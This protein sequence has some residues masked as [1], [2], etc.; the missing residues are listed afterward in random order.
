MKIIFKKQWGSLLPYNQTE[1]D[2][3]DKLKDDV[4]YEVD[5][6]TSSM[7]SIRQNS[8]IHLWCSQISNHL[9]NS[10][11]YV[12]DI[13]KTETKWSMEKVKENIFKA[14]VEQRYGK[15]STTKMLKNEFEDVID[16]IIKAFSS[17]GIVIPQFPNKKD[18][19][20]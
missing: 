12:T 2:K 3:V 20:E 19:G 7:R 15:K 18:L 14:V 16:T 13:I 17:K 6:K 11:L 5:V 4:V 8:A 10:G 1:K 9:N